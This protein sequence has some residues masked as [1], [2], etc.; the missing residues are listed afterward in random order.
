MR[1]LVFSLP[2]LLV[3]TLPVPAEDAGSL[4]QHGRALLQQNRA[5]EA[6]KVLDEAV[7]RS[8]GAAPAYAARAAWSG[9]RGRSGSVPRRTSARD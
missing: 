5:D 9:W 4:V 3:S 6:L 1:P 2:L 8:P 7:R